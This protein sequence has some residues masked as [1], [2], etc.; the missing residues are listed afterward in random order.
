M[1][2]K[3]K[4]TSR[5]Q[6]AKK[7]STNKPKV[8]EVDRTVPEKCSLG[9]I[10]E[11]SSTFEE[12]YAVLLQIGHDSE[13]HSPRVPE[14]WFRV[15]KFCKNKKD[16]DES[17]V[18]FK[19]SIPGHVLCHRRDTFTLICKN[20]N[21]QMNPS[22]VNNKS[23]DIVQQFMDEQEYI[24]NEFV[25]SRLA[26]LK[27]NAD[28]AI[29]EH[30][31]YIRDYQNIGWVKYMRR[32]RN[33][34]DKVKIVPGMH[35]EAER[36]ARDLRRGKNVPDIL[37]DARLVTTDEFKEEER[38]QNNKVNEVQAETN[39]EAVT[40][41]DDDVTEAKHDKD[42]ESDDND[43]VDVSDIEE[44]SDD[45]DNEFKEPIEEFPLTCQSKGQALY[46]MSFIVDKG[47]SMDCLLFFYAYYADDK[48]AHTHIQDVL[49]EKVEP[50]QIQGLDMYKEIYPVRMLWESDAMS[51]RVKSMVETWGDVEISEKLKQRKEATLE[52]RDKKR[53]AVRKQHRE[54]QIVDEINDR[55]EITTQ[56]Q[57]LLFD[58][59]QPDAVLDICRKDN[60]EDRHR[61]TAKLLKHAGK[62]V[63]ARERARK[64]TEEN[65]T[66]Q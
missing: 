5:K 17:L 43:D 37:G 55:L 54:Q 3:S 56:Q 12:W 23:N 4:P 63:R 49:D 62:V 33:I 53:T 1:G 32:L 30:K 26:R 11:P 40:A 66:K 9:Q 57:N 24:D 64:A 28:E 52:G 7:L 15:L 34:P 48:Q 19:E 2:L 38:K 42:E 18:R 60:I 8:W 16:C 14:P 22:Y 58:V 65:K 36:M 46:T 29:D 59:F 50:L 41:T 45:E 61:H 44:F 13:G 39:D 20:F 27:G 21:D 25:N 35:L 51:S 10:G 31:Q 47:D 6:K